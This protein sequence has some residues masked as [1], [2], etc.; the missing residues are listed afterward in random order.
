MTTALPL[1]RHNE[2]ILIAV[3]QK[4]RNKGEALIFLAHPNKCVTFSPFPTA[5]PGSAGLPFSLEYSMDRLCSPYT[6]M[7]RFPAVFAM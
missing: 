5:T 6:P 7:L 4:I 2:P 3:D 1:P